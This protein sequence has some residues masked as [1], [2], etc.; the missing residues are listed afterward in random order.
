M[1]RSV[2]I[3]IIVLLVL[4][5]SFISYQHFFKPPIRYPAGMSDVDKAAMKADDIQA[6]ELREVMDALERND[7]SKVIYGDRF[8]RWTVLAYTL[9]KIDQGNL[10]I[11]ETMKNLM[12]SYYNLAWYPHVKNRPPMPFEGL[13]QYLRADGTWE[14][15]WCDYKPVHTAAF[16]LE[17][18]V[19]TCFDDEWGIKNYP[20]LKNVTDSLIKMWL[21]SR[22]Q[23]SAYID[24]DG[25]KF[26]IMN[27]TC[28]VDSAMV[29]S[30]LISSARIAHLVSDTQSYENY[31][32]YA[33]DLIT[34]FYNQRWDWFPTSTFG[35]NPMEGAG[36]ALQIG[37]TIPYIDGDDEVD[38]LKDYLMKNLR[39]S[40][41]SWLLKWDKNDKKASSRA[42]FAAIGLAPKYPQIAH[43]ILNAYAKAALSKRPWLLTTT[44]G[45]EGQ[46]A[47]WVSGVYLQTYVYMKNRILTGR[48]P[49]S[50]NLM[51]GNLT[52]KTSFPSGLMGSYFIQSPLPTLRRTM[53]FKAN[54]TEDDTLYIIA[55][56]PHQNITI[57]FST[58]F[59]PD[60]SCNADKWGYVDN[61]AQN[62]TIVWLIPNNDVKITLK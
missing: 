10:T 55:E 57:K 30:S 36:T 15:Y 22:H 48:I 19:L 46:D 8:M 28:S 49:F 24:S 31:L 2:L 26:Q 40:E 16:I 34:H 39:I 47:V 4:M 6:R 14:D 45:Y 35:S 41:T 42:V 11:I 58:Q 33:D 18:Y 54:K 7:S 53:Q 32:R 43:N 60:I 62:T 25:E 1:R 12:I 59:K 17:Y 20:V 27:I 38:A 5:L 61:R 52:F 44:D 13:I 23:P 29:Y 3:S 21:P 51:M 56:A 37:M 9:W 50:P